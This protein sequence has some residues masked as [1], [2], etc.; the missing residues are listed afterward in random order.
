MKEELSEAYCF[1]CDKRLVDVVEV[2]FGICNECVE[3]VEFI[4]EIF[5]QAEMYT[6]MSFNLTQALKE[7]ANLFID[8]DEKDYN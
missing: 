8:P 1:G 7:K 6:A 5:E 2:R 4:K 3:D